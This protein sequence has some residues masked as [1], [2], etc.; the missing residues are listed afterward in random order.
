MAGNGLTYK[1]YLRVVLNYSIGSFCKN[2][3]D[4]LNKELFIEV[5]LFMET[6]DVLCR[7]DTF[8][9]LKVNLDLVEESFFF[10]F[11]ALGL[12]YFF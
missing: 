12:K 2:T 7:L 11:Y 9:N 10:V 1:S 3:A 4:W 6:T 8:F 5:Y